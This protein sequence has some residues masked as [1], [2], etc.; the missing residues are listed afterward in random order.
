MVRC[1]QYI[2]PKVALDESGLFATRFAG[3]E[4]T[5]AFQPKPLHAGSGSAKEKAGGMTTGLATTLYA[6][7]RG[8][9]TAHT[10]PGM[11]HSYP[12]RYRYRH[13]RLRPV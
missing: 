12:S 3:T 10:W 6:I 13:L 11:R 1:A 4:R 5:P 8:T 2:L 9:K 7:S